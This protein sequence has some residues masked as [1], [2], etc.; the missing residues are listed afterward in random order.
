M[1]TLL[2]FVV[3]L[4]LMAVLPIWSYSTGW[5]YYPSAGLG[6]ILVNLLDLYFSANLVS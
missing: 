6:L 1:Y 4:L 2:V 3:G 5:G